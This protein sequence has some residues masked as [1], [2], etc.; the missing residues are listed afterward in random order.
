[1][2]TDSCSKAEIMEPAKFYGKRNMKPEKEVPTERISENR[3]PYVRPELRK[4]GPLK[5]MTAGTVGS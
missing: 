2:F 4:F 5:D 3:R 1:M